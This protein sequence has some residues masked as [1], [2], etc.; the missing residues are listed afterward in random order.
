MSTSAPDPR[1]RARARRP[2]AGSGGRAA[3]SRSGRGRVASTM[4]RSAPAANSTRRSVGR[5]SR[6]RRRSARRRWWSSARPRRSARSG[7]P[8]R[9]AAAAR[10]PRAS[11][12][13]AY[14][15]RSNAFSTRSSLPHAPDH[16]A[17][18]VAR[19]A[20]RVEHRP[21]RRVGARPGV[22]GH[23]LLARRVGQ[24]VRVRDEIEEVVGVQVRDDDRVDVDVVDVAAQ[25]REDPVAAV[26]HELRAVRL[27]E[28]PAARP[29]RVLPR[30]RL[31]E[32]GDPHPL[33]STRDLARMQ[34]PSR[35][36]VIEPMKMP[37]FARSTSRGS[38]YASSAMNSDTVKP[39]PAS[40]PM[41]TRWRRRRP[42]GSAPQ[43]ARSA[44]REA[45]GDPDE[46]ADDEPDDD[47]PGQPAAERVAQHAAAQVHARV[48]QREQRDDDEGADRV[49]PVL[50]AL[51]QAGPTRCQ[52]AERDAGDRGVHA[53]LVDERPTSRSRAA[54]SRAAR[55]TPARCRRDDRQQRRAR[56][57]RARPGRRR[58]RR[59]AR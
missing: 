15:T 57:P 13:G 44:R 51:E 32:D 5:A 55:V 11:S 4:S 38:S 39:M 24:R 49:Q 19:A 9:S 43:P 17:E 10:R 52:Q 34:A 23:G 42:S 58:R 53:G 56:P 40:A 16:A 2:R 18:G 48:G 25:L 30:R 37:I 14:S 35:P 12:S 7:A 6:R 27:D 28:V 45:A 47:R 29:A 3:P 21:R 1:A 36:A 8:R 50:E 20:R 26:E 59:R 54:R 41:P 31:A 22:D 33:D 46:L